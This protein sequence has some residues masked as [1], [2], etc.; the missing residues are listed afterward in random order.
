MSRAVVSP[1]IGKWRLVEAAL[2]DRDYLDMS[3][4]AF[5]AF[6]RDETGEIRFGCVIAELNCSYSPTTATFTW[7]GNDEMDEADGDGFAELNDDGT[8]S[9]EFSFRNGDEPL[10]KARKS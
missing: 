4:P 6:K 2:W 9:V 5:V 10:F 8:L 1:L 7:Q 3:G